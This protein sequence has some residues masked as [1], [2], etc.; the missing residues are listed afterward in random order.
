MSRVER[1]L[2]WWPGAEDSEQSETGIQAI[3]QLPFSS[4][5]DNEESVM[6]VIGKFSKLIHSNI[7]HK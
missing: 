6:T 7:L 1:F 2:N 5:H 3:H 4:D